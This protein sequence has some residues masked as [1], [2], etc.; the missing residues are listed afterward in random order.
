MEAVELKPNTH[1]PLLNDIYIKK[2]NK[3]LKIIYDEDGN[4]YLEASSDNKGLN[5]SFKCIDFEI[6]VDDTVYPY[7]KELITDIWQA[8]VYKLTK[9]EIDFCR[10][11]E[12]LNEK[13]EYNKKLNLGLKQTNAYQSLIKEDRI[14]IHSETTTEENANY[15][16]LRIVNGKILL[17]FINNPKNQDSD[18][19]VKVYNS[20]SRYDPFNIC[21]IRL[22]TNLHKY[23][24]SIREIGKQKGK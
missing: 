17:T 8:E 24:N 15:L 11:E 4:F 20:N 16:I 22:F 10:Y 13:I 12:E 14:E 7:F 2:D 23:L 18:F 3:C 6:D 9:L 21:F 5:N 19:G 1:F